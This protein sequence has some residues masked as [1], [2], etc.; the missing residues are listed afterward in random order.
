MPINFFFHF[1]RNYTLVVTSYSYCNERSTMD[2]ES[3]A[4]YQN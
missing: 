2:H 3:V 1:I 4:S